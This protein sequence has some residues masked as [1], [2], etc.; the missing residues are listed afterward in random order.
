MVGSTRSEKAKLEKE[1]REMA[2][3]TEKLRK[4][5]AMIGSD[6]DVVC[7]MPEQ[8]RN[9]LLQVLDQCSMQ[10][11]VAKED[12]PGQGIA[13]PVSSKKRGRLSG[14]KEIPQPSQRT[15]T[16]RRRISMS[17]WS[18]EEST[19][20]TTV[21]DQASKKEQGEEGSSQSSTV[22]SSQELRPKKR[23]KLRK[24]VKSKRPKIS[25]T[26]GSGVEFDVGS[27]LE[28][29]I[30]EGKQEV[31]DENL[32]EADVENLDV[33]QEVVCASDESSASTEPHDEDAVEESENQGSHGDHQQKGEEAN[34]FCFAPKGSA[35]SDQVEH[36]MVELDDGEVVEVGAIQ[37]EELDNA[38]KRFGCIT[39]VDDGNRMRFSQMLAEVIEDEKE[40]GRSNF[41]K[42]IL[43]V[44]K[45]RSASPLG[46]AAS[47]KCLEPG[48]VFEVKCKPG[49]QNIPLDAVHSLTREVAAL[50]LHHSSSSKSPAWIPLVKQKERFKSRAPGVNTS[51]IS[52]RLPRKAKTEALAKQRQSRKSEY[53]DFEESP[54]PFKAPKFK[55]D[56]R[57]VEETQL[58][59]AKR[60]SLFDN[61][62]HSDVGSASGARNNN[63]ASDVLGKILRESRE[64]FK[65]PGSPGITITYTKRIDDDEVEILK[66]VS[67][68]P[69]KGARVGTSASTSKSFQGSCPLCQ[70]HFD[71][72]NVLEI[73]ASTCD[74]PSHTQ[75]EGKNLTL[76]KHEADLGF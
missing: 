49:E 62:M 21:Q 41:L 24:L 28:M 22:E 52:S 5:A 40:V 47:L 63:D 1:E 7:N 4:V 8:E 56:P 37:L 65:L 55:F 74:G 69:E 44:S 10:D 38:D 75:P 64:S 73:H 16:P 14:T 2:E 26:Q 50:G 19:S 39:K 27:G 54:P 45:Q 3:N 25:N 30:D 53:E 66:E 68:S 18:E 33:V 46:I 58:E 34:T 9:D 23:S 17:H 59:K 15:T 36:E 11:Q 67:P 76:F 6:L 12:A 31:A 35:V 42:G 51:P 43:L 48:H 29:L 72:Q 61:L 60:D 32:A 20:S 13:S 57:D 70:V 71:D